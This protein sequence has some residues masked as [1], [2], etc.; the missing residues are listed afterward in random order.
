[1]NLRR[2]IIPLLCSAFYIAGAIK[3]LVAPTTWATNL[4]I[5]S[6]W[7]LTLLWTYNLIALHCAPK[8]AALQL[9]GRTLPEWLAVGSDLLAIIALATTGHFA[10]A[11]AV[12]WML[13]I[14]RAYYQQLQQTKASQKDL[15]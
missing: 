8:E 14:E 13:L 11:M 15:D 2:K 7:V 12:V 10:T 1:M 3:L 4:L 5:F 9:S 6:C